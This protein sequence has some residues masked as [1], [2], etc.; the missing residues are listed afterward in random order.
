MSTLQLMWKELVHR[1]GHSLL[2]TCVVSAIVALIVSTMLLSDSYQRKTLG[3]VTQLDD[4]IRK[5]MKQLGFN[6]FILPKDLNLQDFFR[7]D[8][9]KETMD[10]QLVQKL[11]DAK[12]VVTI[13]HLRP[14]LVQKITWPEKNRDIIVMGVKGVVPWSHR[15]NPKKPLAQPVDPGV[16]NLG[17]VL[18]E[19]IK[20]AKGDKL[21]LDGNS[22]TVGTIYPPRGNQDDITAWVDLSLVQELS[23]Q[24]GKINMIQALNCNCASV[25]ALAE[26]ESEIS[27]V[28]GN[29]VKVIELNSELI[30]R[31]QARTKVAAS[32]KETLELLK[33]ASSIGF[34]VLTVLGSA[35]LALIFLR[36]ASERASEVGMLRAIG[37]TRNQILGLFLGKSAVLGLFGGLMGL[38]LG[39]AASQVIANVADSFLP[40]QPQ[41]TWWLLVPTAAAAISMLAT[42]IPVEAVTGRDPARILREA[43]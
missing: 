2:A 9:G 15:T 31:A 34:A 16:V 24:A 23:Q 21:T 14:A 13:N 29:D 33:T 19:E 30:T 12:G 32:G 41:T 42:W 25:D 40:P 5:T 39:L 18:A 35:I 27:G 8:F 10:E 38:I 3:T 11:A 4:D 26:I 28:L 37:V 17:H 36:N 1:K 20:A 6:I 43:S 22:L 7:Q